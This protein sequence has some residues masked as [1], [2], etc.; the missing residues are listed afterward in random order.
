MEDID[1][2]DDMGGR[3]SPALDSHVSQDELEELPLFVIRKDSKVSF[4]LARMQ[5]N[6]RLA[7]PSCLRHFSRDAVPRIMRN[8]I[9]IT[10]VTN[11]WL[12]LKT[13]GVLN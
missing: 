3:S 13:G 9:R 10:Y 11:P 1:F 4:F 7:L 6:L 2:T 5:L 8:G 12:Y